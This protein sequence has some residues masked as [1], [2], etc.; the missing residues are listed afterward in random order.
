MRHLHL[1]F[2]PPHD[3][4]PEALAALPSVGKLL[5]RGRPLPAPACLS[6]AGCRALG[7]ARQQDW[8]VAPFTAQAAGL[9]V[10]DDY[11]LRLDPVHLEVG[12][13]GL[14]L[15]AGMEL[16]PHEADTL[17]TLIF[18]ILTQSGLDVFAG[19]DG[20]MHVRCATPPRLGTTPLDQVDGRQPVRFLPTG[21][22]APF[23]NHLMHEAQMALHEHPFNLARMASGKLPVNS[24]WTWGGGRFKR[25]A[26]GTGAL[27]GEHPLLRQISMALDIPLHARPSGLDQIL[28]EKTSRG[29]LLLDGGTGDEGPLEHRLQAWE[30]AWFRPLA[31]ALLLGRLATAEVSL[32]DLE[33][34]A[35]VLTPR[36]VW[37]FWA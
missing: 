14:F 32:L 10:G 26:R 6:E 34:E 18:P 1:V 22:D 12:M 20:I 37:R 8:P 27:W 7:I 28:G 21:E 24:F 5:R 25:P 30:Q 19:A 35:R 31:K 23:W 11:W 3:L 36:D 29:L 2:Q 13:R 16:D 17:G 9:E 33:A 4:N 15:R